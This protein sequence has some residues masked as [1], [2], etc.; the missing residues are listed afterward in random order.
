MISRIVR[1][2]LIFLAVGLISIGLSAQDFAPMEYGGVLYQVLENNPNGEGGV[3]IIIYLHGRH[4]SGSDNLRQINQA[5]VR[6][7]TSYIKENNLK[8][9]FLVPQC[10]EDHG[11][12][13][14]REREGYLDKV[15]ALVAYYVSQ[16]KVDTSR[17]YLC[18]SSMGA[19]GA[20]GLIKDN[21]GLFAAAIIASGQA[22]DAS[23]SDFTRIPLYV[24]VGSD[25]RSTDALQWFT[26]QIDREG[27][28]VRFDIL[29]GLRHGEACAAAFSAKRLS[30]LY[31]QTKRNQI[32][33]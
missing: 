17:I 32:G 10:P 26:N 21:P 25:E 7:I 12:V 18:G 33:K 11:W 16:E 14:H 29:Q 3:P 13:K 15:E 28:N 22:I 9:I 1:A 30:W 31:E 2:I 27:G 5:A 23:P 8:V 20:W 6:N 19:V 4:A 24:T